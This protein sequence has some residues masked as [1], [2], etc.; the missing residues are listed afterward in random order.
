MANIQQHLKRKCLSTSV[1]KPFS[2]PLTLADV[3]LRNEQL[4][5]AYFFRKKLSPDQLVDSLKEILK[6]YPLLGANANFN[7]IPSVDCHP[8]DTVPISFSNST[9]TLTE[10]MNEMKEGKQ[11]HIHGTG[12]LTLMPLFDDL[13]AQKWNDNNDDDDD[14]YLQKE[15]EMTRFQYLSTIKVT[16]FAGGEGTSL[17]INLSHLLGDTNSCIRIAQ[18]WG[19]EMRGLRH[20]KGASNSRFNAAC[21]GMITHEQADILGL[22]D[23]TKNTNSIKKCHHDVDGGGLLS[24]ILSSSRSMFRN[25]SFDETQNKSNNQ[26]EGKNILGQCSS[27]N[28]NKAN[29]HEYI[30]LKFSPKLLKAMKLYGMTHAI[31]TTKSNKNKKGAMDEEENFV[32]TN[33]MVTAYSWLMKRHLSGKLDY[34]MSMV[35]NLRGRCGVD[36]FSDIKDDTGKNGIF[37]NAITNVIAEIPTQNN[38][39]GGMKDEDGMLFQI[40][41]AALLIREALNDGIQNIP[42]NLTLSRLG[43]R[44]AIISSQNQSFSTTSWGQFPL[45]DIIKFSNSDEGRLIGFHGQPAYPLPSGDTYS[46]VLVP[47]RCGALLCQILAPSQKVEEALSFHQKVSTQFLEWKKKNQK[48][49]IR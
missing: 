30:R 15:E 17:G 1:L 5:F 13:S 6:R 42:D 2:V 8:D 46:S 16:Y 28:N 26:E 20:P 49:E 22:N 40:G 19:R 27:H 35:I 24:T 44:N 43:K 18:C 14:N 25:F 37:G 4:P 38:N 29:N 41:T 23:N 10:G 21:A 32:S 36:A 9:L 45:W 33:D 31:T 7:S 11:Q 48:L 34:G 12:L 47:E 3:H 39:N